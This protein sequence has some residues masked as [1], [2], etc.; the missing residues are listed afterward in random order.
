MGFNR[1]PF[2]SLL[3]PCMS[4]A[5]TAVANPLSALAPRVQNLPSTVQPLGPDRYRL[6]AKNEGRDEQKARGWKKSSSLCWGKF[7]REALLKLKTKTNQHWR[8]IL[9]DLSLCLG[10]GC[11]WVLVPAHLCSLS[12]LFLCNRVLSRTAS[13]LAVFYPWFFNIGIYA[14]LSRFNRIY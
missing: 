5:S 14:A 1:A 7:H 4:S 8:A 9:E 13:L 3:G 12:G 2:P 6:I 11:V 10:C